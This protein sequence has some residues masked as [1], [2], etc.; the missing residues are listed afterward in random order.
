MVVVA[1]Y[2]KNIKRFKKID[3]GKSDWGKYS[4]SLEFVI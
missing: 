1:I 2:Q 3:F 4:L